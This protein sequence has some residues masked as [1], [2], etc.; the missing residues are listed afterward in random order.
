MKAPPDHT[1]YKIL[2]IAYLYMNTV[3]YIDDTKAIHAQWCIWTFTRVTGYKV[4][5]VQYIVWCWHSAA[6]GHSLCAIATSDL[7]SGGCALLYTAYI[8]WRFSITSLLI[9]LINCRTN[10]YKSVSL[11]IKSCV[12]ESILHLV[13]L[14]ITIYIHSIY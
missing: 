6:L 11:K 9:V 12:L 14:R 4:V 8:S 3:A 1:R 7:E 2:S 13:L 5:K 10:E